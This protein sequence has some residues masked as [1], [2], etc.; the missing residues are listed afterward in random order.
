MFQGKNL[1]YW[2]DTIG[3][4]L[5]IHV[6]TRF[7]SIA[8]LTVSFISP[9]IK[10]IMLSLSVWLFCVKEE[11]KKKKKQKVDVKCKMC[12]NELF[13][14]KIFSKLQSS[15]NT[16]KTPIWQELEFSSAILPSSFHCST[17]RKSETFTKHLKTVSWRNRQ[18]IPDF[19]L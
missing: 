18:C 14:L 10:A 3:A 12:N 17:L 9:F 2:G 4:T 11:T 1:S 5:I 13:D 7:C 19:S 8:F 6:L 15:P 16:S